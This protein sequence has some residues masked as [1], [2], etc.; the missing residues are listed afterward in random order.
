MCAILVLFLTQDLEKSV[1]GKTINGLAQSV[2][3]NLIRQKEWT[4][5][6]RI[7]LCSVAGPFFLPDTA[8]H[9]VFRQTIHS[10]SKAYKV[11]SIPRTQQ[12]HSHM[13]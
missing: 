10:S 12:Q 2:Y 6:T 8:E 13:P 7:R 9:A 4:T 1:G 11:V 3:F 5:H